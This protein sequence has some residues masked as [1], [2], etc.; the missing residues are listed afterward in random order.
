MS[1]LKREPDSVWCAMSAEREQLCPSSRN[2][3]CARSRMSHAQGP[4]DKE[5]LP[6]CTRPYIQL[7]R[8][9]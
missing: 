2:A 6:S 8:K 5:I 1:F 7:G 4:H 3:A 9:R